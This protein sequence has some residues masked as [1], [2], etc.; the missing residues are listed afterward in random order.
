M[1]IETA[2]TYARKIKEVE[3]IEMAWLYVDTVI[4]QLE[5]VAERIRRQRALTAHK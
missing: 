2:L 5:E 4:A 1:N 3:Q